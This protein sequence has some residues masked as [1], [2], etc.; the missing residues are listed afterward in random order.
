LIK[1]LAAKPQETFSATRRRNF[2]FGQYV[3]QILGEYGGCG[4]GRLWV[5]PAACGRKLSAVG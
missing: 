1:Q 2:G 4:R 3:P 5:V